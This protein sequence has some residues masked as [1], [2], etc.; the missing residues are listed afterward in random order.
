VS[1]RERDREGA[2]LLLW[3]EALL[4]A[5]GP[6]DWWPGRSRREIILGAILTQHTAWT[7][8]GAAIG[9]LRAAGLLRWAT[10]RTAAPETILHCI[11][12][13]GTYRQQTRTILAFVA[14]VEARHGGSLARLARDPTDG[15][16]GA[17]L[18]TTGIGPETADSILLYGFG[19]PLFVI[20]AYALRVLARHGLLPAGTRY[21]EAQAWMAA[22]LP[23]DARLLN[24]FHAQFVWVGQRYCRTRPRCDGCPLE[25]FLPAGGRLR[26]EACP[27]RRTP[28]RAISQPQPRRYVAGAR[29]ATEDAR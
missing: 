29:G 9:A 19:R 25:P 21:A 16:R 17:L 13:A 11:R 8:A 26:P 1:R 4:R 6:R 27:S 15:L 3:H 23:A 18:A 2:L 28:R 14:M 20:D 12:P 22:R 7:N 24:E 5:A 10:L